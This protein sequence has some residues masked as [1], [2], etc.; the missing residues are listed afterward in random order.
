MEKIVLLVG[1]DHQKKIFGEK[2]YDRMRRIGE[3]KIYDAD[4]YSDKEYVKS[5]VAGATI[6]VTTW[7]SPVIDKDILDA[8]PDLKA[9][10]HAAVRMAKLI[11]LSRFLIPMEIPS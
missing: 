8:C 5:F 2:Y 3:V 10:I 7:G 6:I 9:V 1:K 4:S 11:L